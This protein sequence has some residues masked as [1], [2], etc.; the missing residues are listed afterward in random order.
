[1]SMSA[2]QKRILW[3]LSM[4]MLIVVIDSAIVNVALPAMKAALHF[5]QTSLQWVL[6]AYILT[7]GAS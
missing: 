3:L 5:N 1:M 4:V 6:T 2:S 7:F